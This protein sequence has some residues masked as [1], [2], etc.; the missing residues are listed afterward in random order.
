MILTCPECSASYNVPAEAIGPEG[1]TVRCKKCKHE[2]F[3]KGEK[4]ALEDLINMIESTEIEVDDIAFDDGKKKA[5]PPKAKKEKIPLKEKLKPLILKLK[6]L[7]P[8]K[9]KNYLFSGE[10]RSLLSHF[11]SF[12]VALATFSI[13]LLCLV[14]FRWGITSAIPSFGPMYEAAGFPL[15][16][17]AM[18]N[19]EES[20]T[21]D[22][23]TLTGEG[24]AR[25]MTGNLI[26]LT[27]KNIKVPAIKLEYMDATGNT[28]HESKAQLPVKVIQK[29]MSFAF[30]IVIPADVPKNFTAIKVSFIE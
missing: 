26:N 25:E 17:Y 20:L 30:N 15:H 13:M 24:D 19:P 12:M 27:S 5:L 16:D 6:K 1:R 28:I 2:W 7:E 21:I 4:K 18:L 23:V 8:V 9:L 10:K 14:S 29:E 11:A 22:R 3:Q